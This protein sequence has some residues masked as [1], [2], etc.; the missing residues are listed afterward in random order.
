MNPAPV[1]PAINKNLSKAKNFQGNKHLRRDDDLTKS[2]SYINDSEMPKAT[3]DLKMVEDDTLK[4]HISHLRLESN[5]KGILSHFSLF[6]ISQP[7]YY[8]LI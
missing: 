7:F 6:T 4:G 1:E 5:S 2:D 3:N 8:I